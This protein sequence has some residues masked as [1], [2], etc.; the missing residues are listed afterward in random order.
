M[1]VRSGIPVELIGWHLSRAEAVLNDQDIAQILGLDTKLAHFAM[2]CNSHAR[3]AYKVQTGEDGISLPD[4]IAMCVALDP[5]VGTSWSSHY[6]DVET[7]SELTRGM[8][9]VDR[10]NVAEDERNRGEW[11]EITA[12]RKKARVCWTLDASRW[13]SAL[14][15]ALRGKS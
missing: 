4:P 11:S 3:A 14:L 15:A 8:T 13:K 9:V 7:Q 5:S 1:V 6:L 10:L 2:E 12:K